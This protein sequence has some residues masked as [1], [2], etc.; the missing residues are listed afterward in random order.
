MPGRERYCRSA[1]IVFSLFEY[2]ISLLVTGAFLAAILKQIGIADAIAG[3]ISSIISLSCLTQL[4]SGMLIKPGRSVRRTIV[5]LIAINQFMFS[6]LYL[7]PFIH[8]SQQVKTVLFILMITGAYFIDNLAHPIKY[9][10]LMGFVDP[11]ERGRF[12]A[13]KEMISLIGGMLFTLAMG[14]MVDYCNDNGRERTGFILCGV[15]IALIAMLC[16]AL[17]KSVDNAPQNL[18]KPV[19]FKQKLKTIRSMIAS[20][21]CFRKLLLVDILW[22]SALY[23]S[24]PFFG[25]YLIGELSFSLTAVSLIGIVSGL[26]RVLISPVFGRY[27]DKHGYAKAIAVGF[28]LC[29]T[30]FLICSFARPGMIRLLYIPYAILDAIALASVNGGLVNITYEYLDRSLF[31]FALGAKSA[32]SGV[33]GFLVS[34]LGSAAVRSVQAR[35]SLLFGHTI[36]AQQILSAVSFLVIAFL[37]FYIKRVVCKLPRLDV[38]IDK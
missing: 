31:A 4:F 33:V 6:S 15:A 24:T 8:I 13:R 38:V 20:N 27:A 16:F 35:G 30:G 2:L 23:V 7:I 21:S 10:W 26:S 37:V 12:T 17:I 18:G 14:R 5:T 28:T 1:F 34:L 29:A 25:T 3:V 36:Y 9:D 19:S 22:K 11:R 32:I